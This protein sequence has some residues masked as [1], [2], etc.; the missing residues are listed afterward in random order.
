MNDEIRSIET[1]HTIQKWNSTMNL[2]RKGI[3][4]RGYNVRP[5]VV[6]AVNNVDGARILRKIMPT[7][8][9]AEHAALARVHLDMAARCLTSHATIVE[10]ASQETFGR[11]YE[12]CDYKVALIVSDAYPDAR[13]EQLRALALAVTHHERA[14]RAHAHLGRVKLH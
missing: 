7:L 11:R 3:K 1:V 5:S 10:C 6:S 4:L 2:Y 14:A 8:T 13:K 12:F 9:E